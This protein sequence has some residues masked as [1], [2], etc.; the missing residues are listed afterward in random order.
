MEGYNS[1][2]FPKPDPITDTVTFPP[3]DPQMKPDLVV[4]PSGVRSCRSVF[5]PEPP[6][7]KKPRML[8]N[9]S[10][11]STLIIR[12]ATLQNGATMAFAVHSAKQPMLRLL[13]TIHTVIW[14]IMATANV[15]AFYLAFAG[16][17]NLWFF[18]SIALLGGEIFVIVINR[19]HCPLTDIM[20]R[21]TTERRPNFDIY[22]PNGWQSTT[23][24]SSAY[25]SPWK[26]L[27]SWSE[28]HPRSI[29]P[30]NGGYSLRGTPD[31]WKPYSGAEKITAAAERKLP[32]RQSWN[33]AVA[34]CCKIPLQW[35]MIETMLN[36]L[37]RCRHRSITV[38]FT[39]LSKS[40]NPPADTYV[41]CLDC[42]TQLHYDWTR[43][44]IGRPIPKSVGGTRLHIPQ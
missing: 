25:S 24:E 10:S 13:K 20:A 41:T 31:G 9:P 36:L 38:P 40:G 27:W 18:I 34:S 14:V 21:Y 1:R 42:G 2:E 39:P 32:P 22:F 44:R 29:T 5:C 30:R 23:S 12:M 43:M 35:N 19:W 4:D 28:V 26:S 3:P 7:S 8:P 37:F 16:R 11:W 17:F 15:A 6:P 33:S